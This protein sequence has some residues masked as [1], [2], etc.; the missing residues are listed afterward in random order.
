[1]KLIFIIL[2]ISIISCSKQAEN[3]ELK[4]HCE[5]VLELSDKYLQ[6]D[7]SYLRTDTLFN[8]VLCD[9]VLNA[10]KMAAMGQEKTFSLCS[11]GI[12]EK[13]RFIYQP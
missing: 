12:L 4:K 3:I 2:T 6:T 9:S 8:R 13:R 10:F 1:M 7:S 11:I 5:T